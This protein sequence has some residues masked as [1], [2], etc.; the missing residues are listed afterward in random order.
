[1][2]AAAYILTRQGWDRLTTNA[3]AERA[4]VNIGS[5]YQYFP[6]KESIIFELYRR[7]IVTVQEKLSAILSEISTQQSLREAL[8]V[9]VEAFVQEHRID[10]VLHRA[11]AE[12]LPQST[13]E[14]Q[15][16]FGSLDD[17]MLMALRP[18]MENVPDPQIAVF[19]VRTAAHAIVHEAASHQPELLDSPDFVPELVTLLES[20]LLRS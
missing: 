13:L 19:F 11:F 18:F 6:N 12:E 7:H 8:T 2:Q 20:Y 17:R 15:E 9:L 14:N 5:L 4:G 16:D 10:P 3:I 1:M